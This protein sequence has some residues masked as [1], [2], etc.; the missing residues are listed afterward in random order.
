[1]LLSAAPRV[2]ANTTGSFDEDDDTAG[3]G[4]G[5]EGSAVLDS[6]LLPEVETVVWAGDS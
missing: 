4:G 6:S 1:M 3:G 5:S 2:E